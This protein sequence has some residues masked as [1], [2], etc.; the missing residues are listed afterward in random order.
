MYV[1]VLGTKNGKMELKKKNLCCCMCPAP[2]SK[3]G[4]KKKT[5]A[6]VCAQRRKIGIKS[7]NG[8]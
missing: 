2:A 8:N 1:Q 7:K 3:N 5:F 6:A 4:N